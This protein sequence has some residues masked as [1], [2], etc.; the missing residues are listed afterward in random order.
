[1]EN[2]KYRYKDNS[3]LAWKIKN[4][5]Y[6]S[7]SKGEISI[8]KGIS[9]SSAIENFV[10]NKWNAKT[11]EEIKEFENLYKTE[12]LEE[13]DESHDIILQELFKKICKKEILLNIFYYMGG[14][15]EDLLIIS[16]ISKSTAKILNCE[17]AYIHLC[18]R[19]YPSYLENM[20][21]PYTWKGYWFHLCE[22]TIIKSRP[23]IALS[24]P[25]IFPYKNRVSG[26]SIK[27]GRAH[28]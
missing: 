21:S 24:M 15:P 3:T 22:Q 7:S 6:H 17:D 11:E 16:Q 18:Q 1:M 8:S 2:Y 26:L 25:N 10:N 14:F 13:R 9:L 4:H 20:S 23:K 27:I 5:Q 28:V 12:F 19:H